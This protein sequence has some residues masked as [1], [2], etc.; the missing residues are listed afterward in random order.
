MKSLFPKWAIAFF[1]FPFA[2]CPPAAAAPPGANKA[3]VAEDARARELQAEIERRMREY[4]RRLRRR[5]IGG[6]VTEARFVKYLA[7]F[8]RKI[9]C[10][11]LH[12]YPEAARGKIYGKLVL[13]V[14]ILADGTFEKAEISHSS[15]HKILDA[16][17]IDIARRAA[18]YDPFPPEIR[19]DTDALDISRTWSFTYTEEQEG[20]TPEMGAEADP[21][22]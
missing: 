11:S 9:A 22:A 8:R 1:I 16:A 17:A 5:Q 13:T 18:P 10:S 6:E 2:A 21:C 4:E 19:R 14:S 3:A 12:H 15:G 7:A 20:E